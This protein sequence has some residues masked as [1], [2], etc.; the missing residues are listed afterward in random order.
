MNSSALLGNREHLWNLVIIPGWV[1]EVTLVDHHPLSSKVRVT[2]F[3]SLGCQ[4]SFV[5]L[6][7]VLLDGELEKWT[8]KRNTGK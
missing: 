1:L 8:E 6:V 2:A 5:I 4:N 7:G 3:A